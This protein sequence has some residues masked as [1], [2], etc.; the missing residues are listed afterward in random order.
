MH[1]PVIPKRL[2]ARDNNGATPPPAHA[3][4][5]SLRPPISVPTGRRR[6]APRSGLAH[7]ATEYLRGAPRAAVLGL[8][9]AVC[10][11]TL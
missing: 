5:C 6:A 3:C 10:R 7:A 2:S 11:A 9:G 8:S 4:E 1:N